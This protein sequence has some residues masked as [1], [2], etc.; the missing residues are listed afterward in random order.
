MPRLRTCSLAATAA[1]IALCISAAQAAAPVP[2]RHGEKGPPHDRG[3]EA[4]PPPPRH[5]GP[6]QHMCRCTQ[7]RHGAEHW[8]H[9]PEGQPVGRGIEH[10]PVAQDDLEQLVRRIVREMMVEMYGEPGSPGHG[11]HEPPPGALKQRPGPM[12]PPQVAPMDRP[13]AAP[14][15]GQPGIP[16]RPREWRERRP[17]QRMKSDRD[18]RHGPRPPAEARPSG[19]R[20]PGAEADM[21]APHDPSGRPAARR[22]NPDPRGD[23]RPRPGAPRA[24]RPEAGRRIE[25]LDRNGDGFLTPDEFPGR[26]PRFKRLD[27]DGDGR[28][29]R[30][31]LRRGGR[32]RGPRGER[33]RV[34]RAVVI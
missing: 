9:A 8:R 15:V 17:K 20:R 27:V 30:D 5:H 3:P 13:P 11:L 24:D 28:L 14:G 21:G 32:E 25:Q 6:G 22:R 18:L 7:P 29:S 10:G 26:E 1:A 12:A 16:N 4:G 2:P 34:E 31:E 19:P 23:V 33:V